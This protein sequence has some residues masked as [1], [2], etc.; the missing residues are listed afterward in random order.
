MIN[1]LPTSEKK[2][3]RKEYY[4]R[5]LTMCLAMLAFVC[6]AAIISFLP[7]YLFI[8]SRHGA[9][10]AE[11][12]SDETQSRISRV[13]EMETI[14]RD[15][16]KK[17]D[18]LKNGA[19]SL[20]V[21]DIFLNILASKVPGVVITGLSYDSGGVASK[22]GKDQTVSSP[23]VGI[24]GKS[25]DRTAL[26]AFKDTLAREKEF[27]SVDLPISSLIKDTDLSFSINITII[28]GAPGKT[29]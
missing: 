7:T 11:S 26:L 6:I 27:G 8:L 3:I 28:S 24:Q 19:L 17:I 10:L 16:N 2:A 18:L 29:K 12:R 20:R 21:G 5:V 13:K 23:S 9:F 15:T 25:S 4:L 22:K 1:L 14:V